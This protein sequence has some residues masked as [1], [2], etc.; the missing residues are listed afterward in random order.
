MSAPTTGEVQL[1]RLKEAGMSVA[2]MPCLTDV[3]TMADAVEVAALAPLSDD[4]DALLPRLTYAK[5]VIDEVLRLYPPSFVIVRQALGDDVAAGLAIPR[6]SL[7]L[8]A[9]WVLHRHRRWWLAP[10]R[11]DPER[12]LPGA[13]PPPPFAYMPFGIGPRIC[14]GAPFAATELLLVVA[15]LVQAFEVAVTTAEPVRPVGLVTL[16][17]AASPLFTLNPRAAS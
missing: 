17:P 2:L 6:G 10:D 14:V 1:R 15:T 16:Q 3:D 13:P 8:I 7:V 11:F 4:V 5:A 9:P 12:F